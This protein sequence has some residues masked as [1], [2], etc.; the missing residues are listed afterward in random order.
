MKKCLL[1]LFLWF[2][3][4]SFAQETVEA[5]QMTDV[6]VRLYNEKKADS[7]FSKY[8]EDMR[9]ALPLQNNRE[10]IRTFYAN[11]GEITS[12][13]YYKKDGPW[14]FY[15]AS[16]E[17]AT[18]TLKMAPYKGKIAGFKFAPYK[19]VNRQP[20]MLRNTTKMQL[21]FEGT[22]FVSPGGDRKKQNRHAES[23]PQKYALDLVILDENGKSHK[24]T[25]ETNE[26]Y[27]AFGQSL[28]APCD[29][30]VVN[31]V[32]GVKDNIPGQKDA[33][34]PYGNYILLKTKTGEHVLLA[35]FK[36]GSI[37]VKVGD[38]VTQGQKL[39]ACGNSGNSSEPHLH[40]H[41][42]DTEDL[43]DSFGIKCFFETIKVNCK[44]KENYAPVRFDRIENI[45]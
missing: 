21:P 17:K 27:Y 1:I 14:F 43:T 13:E 3:V 11:L 45:N 22:W 41:L 44:K 19:E 23:Q 35:H 10:F 16:M 37:N 40:F 18:M 24:G 30:L 38:Q 4:F 42:Q 8:S 36:Q 12:H 9:L 29:A 20:L 33:S 39:G 2:N 32:D 31:Y 26:D 28:Y 25:G 6:F 34:N 15:K 5:K 7:L